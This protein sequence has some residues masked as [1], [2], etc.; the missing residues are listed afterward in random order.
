MDK[1]DCKKEFKN[2]YNPPSKEVVFVD[3]PAFNFLMIDGVGDPGTSQDYKNAV[4]ALF[5]LSYTLKFM[6]KKGK[7]P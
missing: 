7:S 6:V 4:E 3:V 1:I 5:A 2:L